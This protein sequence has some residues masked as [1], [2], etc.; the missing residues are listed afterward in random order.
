MFVVMREV[1][2]A[3]GR[4]SLGTLTVKDACERMSAGARAGHGWLK[5]VRPGSSHRVARS[6]PEL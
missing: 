3:M 4:E 2:S 1:L 6:V 5:V